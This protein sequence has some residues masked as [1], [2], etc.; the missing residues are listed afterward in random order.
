M[1]EQERVIALIGGSHSLLNAQL[2]RLTDQLDIPLLTASDDVELSAGNTKITFFPRAQLLEAIVD[3]FRYWRWNR[4]TLVYEEDHRIRRFEPLLTADTFSHIRFQVIKV[5]RGDYMTAAREVKEVG[6]CRFQARKDCSDFNRVLLDLNPEHTYNFLLAALKMGLIDLKHWFLMTN[7]ELSSMDM[8]LFRH[9]HARYVSPYPVDATFLLENGHIF[10]FTEFQQYVRRKWN[11]KTRFNKNLKMMEAVFTFDAIYT[12]ANIFSEVSSTMTLDDFPAT[13][14]RKPT[15][16]PTRYQHGRKLIDNILNNNLRG[17]SGNLRRLNGHTSSSNYS[18]RIQLI[19]YN[20]NVEDIGF[21]K[22]ATEIH[23]NMSGDSRVQLQKNVQVSDE[24]K[25]HFRVTTIMERPYVMLKKNYNGHYANSKFE[26]FCIDLL[27]ELSA[28]LADGKYGNDVYGNGSWDGMIGEILRGVPDDYQPDLFSFLNPLSWEIWMAIL[29]AIV[30]RV[31]PYEWNLNFSCCTAHQ[32]HPG[33]AFADSPVELSNNYSFWNTLYVTSTMLKGGC[34]FGPRAVSTRLLGGTWW[35]FT[36]VIISAY[37]ANLAAVLT[38]SRPFIPIK[39]I[40][41]LANQSAISYGT[42]KGGS[43]MQFFQESKISSHM[44]IRNF[45]YL[46]EST[47]LE[48]EISQNCNLT[49]IGGVLGSKGYSIALDKKSDWTDRISRQ[50]LLYQKRGIIE[51]KKE[52]WW[53]S[54]GA[55]CTG[56]SSAVKQQRFSLSL[57]NVA[58]LFIILGAGLLFGIVTVVVE[59]IIRCRQIA[60]KENT[61]FWT[62]FVNELRYAV[63]LNKIADHRSRRKSVKKNDTT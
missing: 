44:K 63:N 16:N 11:S 15:R 3:L 19:G 2:E 26:G 48:F 52:K 12:F 54:K 49:Q 58:G 60:K 40:D 20:G 5:Q 56:T 17:L 22:P 30:S 29:A 59:L 21:W 62:E 57:H 50:I 33:A 23:V 6:E 35:V 28:D 34:D 55:A 47:S 45:A 51:M 24:L 7:M 14:C 31:T 39:N 43:T 32:P 13:K 10:N 8:E 42:I 37:T 36:L 9:N 18:M 25:P 61:S 41:D 4:I 46:M 38:V 1:L 27:A 53:R